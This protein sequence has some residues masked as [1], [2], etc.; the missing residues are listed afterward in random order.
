MDGAELLV[1][2]HDLA[3]FA[4]HLLEHREIAD[5]IK[6]MR[7]AQHSGGE[8][9]LTLKSDSRAPQRGGPLL[10]RAEEKR[11]AGA[12]ALLRSDRGQF[13][14]GF[15]LDSGPRQYPELLRHR[16]QRHGAGVRPFQIRF[17]RRADGGRARLEKVAGDEQLVGVKEPIHAFAVGVERGP[18]F[19]AL[20]GVTQQLIDGLLQRVLDA[21]A[22]ELC[23]AERNAVHEQH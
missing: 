16:A 21:G 4:V 3:R 23:H 17:R 13:L 8:N 15:R 1:A 5:E 7:R 11:R 18:D 2:R 20:V 19:P 14:R 10:R 22:L 12:V 9:L 6:Q